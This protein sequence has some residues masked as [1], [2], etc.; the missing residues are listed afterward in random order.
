MHC[1]S[2]AEPCKGGIQFTR[3]QTPKGFRDL[4]P[5]DVA[6]YLFVEGEFR[7]IFGLWGYRE[8]RTSS[9]DYFD[10]IRGGAGEGFTDSLFKVQDCDGKMLSLRGEVT[11]QIA[12]MLTSRA[13][14]EARL[15][16]ISNCI[17]YLETKTLLQ[18]E[19][20]QAGAELIGGRTVDA[21]AE[22]IALAIAALQSLGINDVN[23]DVGNVELFQLAADS[24][25]IGDNCA[26]RRAVASKSIDDLRKL[27]ES[28][29]VKEVLSYIMMKRGGPEIVREFSEVTGVGKEYPEYFDGLFALLDAYGCRG[30]VT[31]DLSTL[32]EMKYYNGTVFDIYSGGLGVPIG[33]GGRYDCMMREFGLEAKATGFAVSVDLCVRLIEKGLGKGFGGGA[34]EAPARIMY[35][36]GFRGEAVRM[37]RRFRDEGKACTIE[38]FD[39]SK[40]GLVVGPDGIRENAGAKGGEGRA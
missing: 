22:A 17:R 35:R 24:L 28:D 21:D 30:R 11:T 29:R 3:F 16:Y 12:R 4:A 33:G 20:W 6:K 37:A 26:I 34:K 31:I 15:F 19:F 27:T 7:K 18:R 32:R 36:D 40:E 10:I 25:G 2:G 23:V 13:R 1:A 38:E 39:G 8:V 9:V 14:D 5:D